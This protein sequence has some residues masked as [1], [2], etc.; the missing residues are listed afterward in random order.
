META[1]LEL[2]GITCFAIGME[3]VGASDFESTEGFVVAVVGCSL[4]VFVVDGR[5]VG[6]FDSR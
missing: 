3:L 5:K 2:V 1:L 6:F 4:L